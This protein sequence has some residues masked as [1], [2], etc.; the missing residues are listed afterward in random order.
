MLPSNVVLFTKNQQLSDPNWRGPMP[1]EFLLE[2]LN[3][4]DESAYTDRRLVLQLLVH[5]S[6]GAPCS[7]FIATDQSL[8]CS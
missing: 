5:Q 7:L 2:G 6:V 4:V 8:K 1:W 3:G